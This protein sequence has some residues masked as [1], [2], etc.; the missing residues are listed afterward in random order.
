MFMSKETAKL[1]VEKIVKKFLA[2][3]KKDLEVTFK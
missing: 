1:E 2:T 3:T